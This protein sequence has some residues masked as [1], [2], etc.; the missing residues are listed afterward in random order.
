M[1]FEVCI[2][3]FPVVWDTLPVA[4]LIQYPFA[5]GA[6]RPFSQARICLVSGAGLFVRLWSFEAEYRCE[7]REARILLEDSC[8][9]ACFCGSGEEYL[10]VTSNAAGVLRIQ[11]CREGGVLQ[12]YE[13]ENLEYLHTFTGEDLQGEYWGVEFLVPEQFLQ[14]QLRFPVLEPGL[15]FRGNFFCTRLDGVKEHF[16]C[17]YPVHSNIPAFLPESFGTFEIVD[18]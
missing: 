2:Q 10:C 5:K 17:L 3:P 11:K 18:Y 13:P 16:G 9:T 1:P 15:V 4:K 14:A 7:E 6:Y 12:E 8:L